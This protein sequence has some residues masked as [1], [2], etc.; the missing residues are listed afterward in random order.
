MEKERCKTCKYF[1]SERLD[2]EKGSCRYN[3]PVA[4]PFPTSHGMT[5]I[6]VFPP[7]SAD[8]WCREYKVDLSLGADKK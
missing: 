5:M 8:S 3:A 7:I 6:G 2:P 1:R 4:M